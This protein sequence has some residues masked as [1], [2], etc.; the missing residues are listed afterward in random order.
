M[1]FFS[2]ASARIH[3]ES[4]RPGASRC[5]L[6]IPRELRRRRCPRGFLGAL[7]MGVDPRLAGAGPKQPELPGNSSGKQPQIPLENGPATFH[8]PD[9]PAFPGFPAV[10]RW[11]GELGVGCVIPGLD[12][13]SD[14]LPGTNPPVPGVGFPAD[15]A[16][17]N[18]AGARDRGAP[19][20]F[21]ASAIPGFHPWSWAPGRF[22]WSSQTIPEL[23]QNGMKST[24]KKTPK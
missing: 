17:G 6:R 21:P 2:D 5:Q 3:V 24:A 23:R 15:V 7:V 22:S 8:F 13:G 19:G 4:S 12:I 20:A 1:E 16:L 9:F 10:W 14:S 18:V 11:P